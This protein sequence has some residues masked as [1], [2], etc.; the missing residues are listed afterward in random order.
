MISSSRVYDHNNV[1]PAYLVLWYMNLILVSMLGVILVIIIVQKGIKKRKRN[2]TGNKTKKRNA[3]N[4]WRSYTRA[5][6]GQAPVAI[7]CALVGPCGLL[8]LLQAKT[9]LNS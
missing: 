9:G 5:Y 7:N 8:E 3:K 1:H 6:W 4:Q 2:L